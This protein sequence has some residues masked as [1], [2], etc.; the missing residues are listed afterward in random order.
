VAVDAL[1]GCQEVVRLVSGFDEQVAARQYYSAIKTLGSLKDVYLPRVRCYAFG[2]MLEASVPHMETKL[3]GA[4]LSDMKDWLYGLKKT[5]RDI[6]RHLTTRMHAKQRSWVQRDSAA[7]ATERHLVSPAVQ[8]VLDEEFDRDEP[9]AVE[10]MPLYQCLHI[11]EK[12]GRRAEFR[13]SFTEDRSNQLSLI[14]DSPVQFVS[15]QLASFDAMLFDIIGFFVVEH[16]ILASAPDFCSRADVDT[17]WEICIARLSDIL[18]RSI[19][20]IRGDQNVSP[21]LQGALTTFSY[22]QEENAYDV[23]KLRD[24]MMAIFGA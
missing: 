3:Q 18:A 10:L 14:L 23:R 13:R 4:A 15:G 20:A 11:N 21:T 19:Q 12:L 16:S 24:L 6:G 7:T 8:F 17:L 5:T 22:V 1:R 2:K 9:V